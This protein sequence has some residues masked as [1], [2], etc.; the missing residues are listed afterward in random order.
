MLNC[1]MTLW[2]SK[3]IFFIGKDHILKV[4]V[5]QKHIS[6]CLDYDKFAEATILLRYGRG[7]RH[8]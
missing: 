5:I 6:W 8:S 3:T 7:G 2:Q 4:F 1:D